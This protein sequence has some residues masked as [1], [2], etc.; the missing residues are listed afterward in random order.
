MI[1]RLGLGFEI[2]KSY[3]K[4]I[5]FL[6]FEHLSTF[7]G[8]FYLPSI[9]NFKR[10]FELLP[11]IL[12]NFLPVF[13]DVFAQ[14]KYFLPVQNEPIALPKNGRGGFLST[15]HKFR[16]YFSTSSPSDFFVIFCKNQDKISFYISLFTFFTYFSLFF[17]FAT[18]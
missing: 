16:P 14:G 12:V 9:S 13:C 7:K 6:L 17:H 4:R 3:L 2:V 15:L 5:H 10:D 1:S 8:N 11:A 18:A